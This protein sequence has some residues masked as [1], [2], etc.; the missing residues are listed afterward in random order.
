MLAET[1]TPEQ[2]AKILQL[3]KSTIYKLI[4]EGEIGAKKI[5]RVYR[6]P[7]KSLSF[8]FNGLDE[9]ILALQ[10]KDEQKAQKINKEIKEARKKI[11]Q[12]TSSF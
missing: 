7:K 4:R 9:D 11:W 5:G 2:V 12:E 6:I 10:Q 3:S 8:V 1:Y